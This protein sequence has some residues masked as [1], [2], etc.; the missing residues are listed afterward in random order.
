MIVTTETT[1]PVFA[2]VHLSST[3]KKLQNGTVRNLNNLAKCPPYPALYASER[4][5]GAD[6]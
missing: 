3:T 6:V 2:G 1:P 4:G 5:I